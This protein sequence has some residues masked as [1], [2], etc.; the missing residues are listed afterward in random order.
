MHQSWL[1]FE[2]HL[3]KVSP[4]VRDACWTDT[5]GWQHYNTSQSL[6]HINSSVAVRGAGSAIV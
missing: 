3:G 4:L 1:V 2:G 5:E 6:I